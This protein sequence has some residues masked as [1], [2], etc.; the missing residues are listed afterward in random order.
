M[1]AILLPKQ[2]TRDCEEV[3]AC[4]SYYDNEEEEMGGSNGERLR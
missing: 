4:P 2:E 1:G 3:L